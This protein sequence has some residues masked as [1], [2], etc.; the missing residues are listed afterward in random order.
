M[1]KNN[2]SF[3]NCE[4]TTTSVPF[5]DVD[6]VK[7]IIDSYDESIGDICGGFIKKRRN[8]YRTRGNDYWDTRWGRLFRSPNVND[9]HSREGKKFRDRFRIPFPLF[10]YLVSLCE[11]DNIFDTI[12]P[13]IIPMEMKVASCLR[14]LGNWGCSLHSKAVVVVSHSEVELNNFL[15]H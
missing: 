14:M 9:P 15:I 7:S 6:I 11:E 3:F 8:Y 2:N 4:Y 13:S 10:K 5:H 12:G 1:S